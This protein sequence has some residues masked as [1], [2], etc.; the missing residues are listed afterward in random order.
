[1]SHPKPTTATTTIIPNKAISTLPITLLLYYIFFYMISKA[2][3][4]FISLL[5]QQADTEKH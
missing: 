5:A 4:T 3:H 1:M 2:H